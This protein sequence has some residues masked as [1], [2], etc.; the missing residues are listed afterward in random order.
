MSFDDDFRVILVV[1]GDVAAQYFVIKIV[2]T[3]HHTIT[4]EGDRALACRLVSSITRRP[5]TSARFLTQAN[6]S[7]VLP[8]S[9]LERVPTEIPVTLA[10]SAKVQSC[11]LRNSRR[12]VP[13]A[14][15]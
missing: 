3:E 1:V 7:S 6:L 2:R 15:A 8:R 13:M 5:N 10:S 4:A 11:S 9:S 12:G 14:L